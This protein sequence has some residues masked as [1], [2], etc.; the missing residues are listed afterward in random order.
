[1]MIYWIILSFITAFVV[2]LF[3]TP[4]L[5][6][7]AK[8][9]RLVDEPSEERKVHSRSIPTIG[10]IMIF[11]AFIFSVCLWYPESMKNMASGLNDLKYLIAT[12]I[13]LFFVGI[14]DDIIGTAPIYKLV[15]HLIVGFIIV[16]MADIRIE[17]MHG[18]FGMDETLPAWA[19]I[20]LTMFVYV[21]VVNAFNLIDG[22]DGLAAGTGFIITLFYTFWFYHLDQPDL[23]LISMALSGSLAGF[24]IFNFNPARIFMGDS[25]SLIIGAIVVVLTIRAIEVQPSETG[26]FAGVSTPVLAMAALSYPLI[27]T[28]RVFT[29]RAIQG[30]SPMSA[31]RNH[32]HHRLMDYGIGHKKTVFILYAFTAIVMA[33]AMFNPIKNPTLN[34][35]STFALVGLMVLLIF[36]FTRT[37]KA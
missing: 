4:S 36:L 33:S 1:M 23:A 25:G 8:L 6:K 20:L 22:V 27:D 37:K 13:I 28:L 19:S 30:R 21:V 18:L 31:D 3:G 29:I 16:L 12:L 14:K 17:S 11:A 2:V 32:I 15:A 10:G 26:M 24:L 35:T 5:I 34:F 9:K 7:V